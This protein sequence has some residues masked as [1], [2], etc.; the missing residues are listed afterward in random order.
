MFLLDLFNLIIPCSAPSNI[1][2][3]DFIFKGKG[4]EISTL[5]DFLPESTI[6]LFF[7]GRLVTVEINVKANG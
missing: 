6:I 4:S 3:I 2:S 1:E 7:V 5:Y